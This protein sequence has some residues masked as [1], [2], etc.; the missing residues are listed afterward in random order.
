LALFSALIVAGA[1]ENKTA[2]YEVM[3][4]NKIYQIV[5]SK[6]FV[7]AVLVSVSVFLSLGIYWAVIGVC[8]GIGEI[9]RLPLRFFLLFLVFL[10][11]CTAGILIVTS[12]R[13]IFG[14]V[15]VYLRFAGAETLVMLFLEESLPESILVK[16]ADWFTLLKLTKILNFQYEITDH[17]VFAV[18]AGMLIEGAVWFGISYIGMKKQIYK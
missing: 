9:D 18:I 6:V 14:A 17:L 13:Q 16:I 3:A 4:G 1:Y 8:N 11:V 5:F 15:L 2:Y 7:D 10:H 12:T